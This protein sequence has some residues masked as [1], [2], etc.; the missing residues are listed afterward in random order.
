[1]FLL[2][3]YCAVRLTSQKRKMARRQ[4]AVQVHGSLLGRAFGLRAIGSNSAESE[5]KASRRAL[6]LRWWRGMWVHWATSVIEQ[7]PEVPEAKVINIVLMQKPLDANSICQ[8]H[9]SKQ[10]AS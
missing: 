2:M 1:M 9:V 5:A 4:S 6:H 3:L 10:M 7:N 8:V